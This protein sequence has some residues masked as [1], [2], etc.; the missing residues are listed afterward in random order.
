MGTPISALSARRRLVLPSRAETVTAA[1]VGEGSLTGADIN[2]AALGAVPLAANAQNAQNAQSVDHHEAACPPK[3]TLI[4]GL[5]FDTASNPVA[6]NLDTASEA[7]AA[8]GGWLP[9]PME[10]YSVKGI[11][12]LGTGTGTSRQ[13]TDEYDTY[14]AATGSDP[15]TVVIDG[16]GAIT[17]VPITDPPNT[18]ASTRWC[19]RHR[20][21]SSFSL[22]GTESG[23]GQTPVFG[24]N[25]PP[26]SHFL[27]PLSSACISQKLGRDA[28]CRPA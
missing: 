7:C 14:D 16:T 10:L 13:F 28:A 12:D 1:K 24:E 2:M 11:L 23:I 27:E 20:F 17:Q 22:N 6:P 25:C 8:K 9:S 3:T 26:G 21:E 18:S 19:A 5:C 15:S 4:R